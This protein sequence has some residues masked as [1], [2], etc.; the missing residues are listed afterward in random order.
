MKALITGIAGFAGSHLAEELLAHGYGVS[1]TR[2]P[3]ES[4]R[5]LKAI[6]SSL[7]LENLDFH[8]P[9]KIS[10]IL[11]KAR[12]DY[13]F[14]LA[15]LSSVGESFRD[16][17]RTYI[18][19]FFGTF[20]MLEAALKLKNLQKFILISSA[21]IY[22]VV[23]PKDIPL[24]TDRLLNPVSPYGVSK[25]AG[26]MMGYQYFENYGLPVV[27]VRSYPHSGPRQGP[28]FVVPDFSRRIVMLE[29]SRT[30]KRIIKVGNLK[31]RRDISDVR[32]IVSGYRLAAEKGKPG[33]IYQLCTGRAHRIS[34]LLNKLIKMSTVKIETRI[35]P[36]LERPTD[37]P[38]LAGDAS[39]A[40]KELGYRRKYSI[41]D[42]LKDCLEYY[43][44]LQGGI[45]G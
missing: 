42:T 18:V 30:A 10:E 37:I 24:T 5:N 28:G 38:V 31:P 40:E 16:P 11:T 2:L 17:Y 27:R 12:P 35:D 45:S 29:N 26:D 13:I 21:D 34:V 15:A 4:L 8:D 25:A 36:A 43:R 39:K 6:K 41:E 9:R 19:N 33:E 20:F 44:M 14:H 1:G 23:K 7:K 22:G 3:G 32:D